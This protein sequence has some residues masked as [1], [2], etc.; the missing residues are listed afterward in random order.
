VIDT[1][2]KPVAQVV[3]EVLRVVQAK[4]LEVGG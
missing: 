3:E 4:R 2:G 1:T